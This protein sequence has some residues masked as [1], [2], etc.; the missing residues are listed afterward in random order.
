[1][2]KGFAL[3]GYVIILLL[4]LVLPLAIYLVSKDS[5]YIFKPQAA[6][7]KETIADLIQ[8]GSNPTNYLLH[9]LKP[10]NFT[11]LVDVRSWVCQDFSQKSCSGAVEYHPWKK[12][13]GSPYI[14]SEGLL[15]VTPAHEPDGR[16]YFLQ[17][18]TDN[19][20]WS[21]PLQSKFDFVCLD[22]QFY[23]QGP[24]NTN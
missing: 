24:K 19:G 15:P 17:L 22:C 3:V 9:L 13:D 1:M 8:T 20:P 11:G 12:S 5:L 2:Q 18:A 23:V 21:T 4:V 14:F 7:K 6:D 10:K 16:I